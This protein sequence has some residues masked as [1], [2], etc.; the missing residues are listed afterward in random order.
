MDKLKELMA[1]CKCSITLTVNKHRDH[2]QSIADYLQEEKDFSN[3]GEM[4]CEADVE[5]KIIETDTLIELQFYPNTPVGFYKVVHYDLD[6]ALD[7]A[8]ACFK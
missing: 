8:L 1:K 6:L 3:D 2:Y 4:L 5:A 7:E